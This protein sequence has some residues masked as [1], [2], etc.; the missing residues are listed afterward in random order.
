[1][2]RV[3]VD[4]PAPTDVDR[5]AV[6]FRIDE[7]GV[8]WIT[9][10]RPESRQNLLT[11]GTMAVLNEVIAQIENGV[12]AGRVRGA[13]FHSGKPGTFIAG[14]D[15]KEFSAI[16]DPDEGAGKAAAGQAVFERIAQLAIPTVA[17]IDGIC[18]GGG[19]ELALACNYRIASDRRETRIG[20]P[21]VQLGILPGFGGTTRLPR[22]VGMQSAAEMILGGKPVD[23]RKAERIGLVDERVHPSIL[24]DRARL[25]ALA[26]GGPRRKPAKTPV[27]RRILDRTSAGRKLVLSQ[28]RKRVMKETGGHYPAPLAAL[29]I[30]EKTLDLSIRES[31]QLEA[32][33][34][35]TLITGEVSR[36]L[37]HVFHLIEA[38]KKA[39]PAAAGRDVERVAVLGAG[40]M[41]GGI[42]QL[43]AY[44]GYHVRMKDIRHEAISLGLRH[45]RELFDGAVRRRRIEKREARQMM[46]RISPTLEYTGFGT[47]GLIIEAVVENM[48]V[49]RS[50]LAET[51]K[52]AAD[53]AILATNTSSLSVSE[54]Q[55]ALK[56]PQNFAGMHFFN[57]VNRMPLVEVIRGEATSDTAVATVF[58]VARKLDKTPI[59]VRDGPGFLVNR[60]LAPYLNEA[61]WLLA[62]GVSV[63]AIDRALRNFGMPMGPFRLLDEVG[64]DVARHA[65]GVMFE[66]FGER[67]RPA[68][69]MA[70]LAATQR[71]GK[72]NERGFYRYEKG[73]A[74]EVDRSI[75]AELGVEPKRQLNAQT[76]VERTTYVMINEAARIL[77]DG[78]VDSPGTVDIG[79]ILGTGFPPFRG[80]LLRYADT[81]GL[82]GILERLEQLERDYGERFTPAPLL[83]ERAAGAGRFYE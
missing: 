43:L 40:V 49:K 12:A 75:Y 11:G 79:M 71:L 21:E 73:R 62:E 67:M 23:A 9:L 22:L 36:N 64:L 28:A 27:V 2:N 44:R 15:V 1:M 18:L 29:D 35:G 76:I 60:I 72:K 5:E 74:T 37:V 78:I 57:P 63:D 81:V 20:L 66:A 30:L 46:D 42:A 34:I 56:R 13:V 51:E 65:G 55:T 80:G 10:D 25:A 68:P 82:A 8:A 7:S 3:T 33:A 59:I 61:G 26:S 6:Q 53:D 41:G 45:A 39:A 16:V 14:A 58:A 47:A 19:T 32:R 17:A 83:R 38:A 48:D 52:H 31:L 69:M 70:A 50:V 54:M 4:L 77:E 24:L